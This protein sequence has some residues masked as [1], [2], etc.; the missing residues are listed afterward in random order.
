MNAQM[1]HGA[2]ILVVEFYNNMQVVTLFGKK[3][4]PYSDLGGKI[5]K[6]DSVEET[7]CREAQEESANLLTIKP[8][9]INQI[10]IPI[11]VNT[12]VAYI[13]YI[14][15][16]SSKDYKANVKQIF[17]TCESKHWK[18]TNRMIRVPLA[19]MI[20]AAN[21][22]LNYVYDIEGKTR[23]IRGRTLAIVKNSILNLQGLAN[24]QPHVLKRKRIKHSDMACLNGT[25]TYI[26][27]PTTMPV[28]SLT[29]PLGASSPNTSFAIFLAPKLSAY[30]DPFLVNCNP[31]WG[32]MH[33]AL[34]GFSNRQPD[35]I[36]HLAYLGSIGSRQWTLNTSTVSV[37]GQ[38]INFSSQTLD[39]IS[40]YL[41]RA[42]FTDVKGPV[43]S[44]VMW[45]MS[46]QC[47]IPSNIASILQNVTWEY[48]R[49]SIAN[50][51]IQWH[52]RF[53]LVV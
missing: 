11:L 10:A 44:G 28:Y 1:V 53:P 9:L 20:D 27:Q 34:T 51:I 46:S 17:K 30:S 23:E 22:S 12:Y 24:Q 19:N 13:L 52:E 32:G 48:V 37:N 16:L 47:A 41:S 38:A 2:G 29:T 36:T 14:T 4:Y 33:I 18:E 15:G 35:V 3:K 31:N 40:H 8:K 43:F 25:R 5:E 7:A 26:V 42:G 21:R 50:N 49:V 39:N 45:H 6:G